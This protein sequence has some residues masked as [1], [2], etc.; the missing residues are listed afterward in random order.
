MQS[1][2]PPTAGGESERQGTRKL[3]CLSEERLPLPRPTHTSIRQETQR[4]KGQG[5]GLANHN[6]QEPQTNKTSSNPI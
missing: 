5:M 1:I 6:H 3:P 2:T 4:G